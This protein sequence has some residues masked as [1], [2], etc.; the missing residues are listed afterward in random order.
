MLTDG[1]ELEAIKTNILPND[2]CPIP[3]SAPIPIHKEITVAT[4]E[5][6]RPQDKPEVKCLMPQLTEDQRLPA[7]FLPQV[8]LMASNLRRPGQQDDMMPPVVPS[9]S[10]RPCDV[11]TKGIY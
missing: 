5:L 3:A 1:Q 4:K 8:P 7:M 9:T 2:M 6:P 10:T 11:E